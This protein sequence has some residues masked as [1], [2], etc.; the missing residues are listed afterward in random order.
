MLDITHSPL[1]FFSL[2]VKRLLFQLVGLYAIWVKIIK[3]ELPYRHLAKRKGEGGNFHSLLLLRL[4]IEEPFQ[5]SVLQAQG[6]ISLFSAAPCK[7]HHSSPLT[8]EQ[9]GNILIL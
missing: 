7:R 8:F 3:P 9:S 5:F 6:C 2:F 4:I 1:F